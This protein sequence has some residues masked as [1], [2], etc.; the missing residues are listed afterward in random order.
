MKA[1]REQIEAAAAA[2]ANMRGGRRGVPPISNVLEA[3]SDKL[4]AEVIEDGEAAL[5]AVSFGEIW[6]A[7][8]QSVKLQSHYAE[9]LNAHDG[10][11]RIGFDGAGEWLARLQLLREQ[12]Q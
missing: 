12:K 3:L 8:E 1:T 5:D 11:Q 4:R 9:L 7:L 6:H 10:G 2:I